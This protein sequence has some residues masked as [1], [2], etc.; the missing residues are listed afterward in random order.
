MSH[1]LIVVAEAEIRDSLAAIL[2]DEGYVVT[3]AAHGGRGSLTLIR[4]AVYD[5]VLLDVWL[6]DRDG[7]DAAARR[8]GTMEPSANVPEIIM[9]SGHG[10]IEAAVRATK[11]GAYDFLEKPLSLAAHADCA[12]ERDAAHGSLREDNAGACNGSLQAKFDRHRAR[13]C[14]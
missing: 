10:T 3:T 14:P 7:L 13:A 9:I 4:D 2:S 8:S 12:A 1:V 11:L 5:V 6:P